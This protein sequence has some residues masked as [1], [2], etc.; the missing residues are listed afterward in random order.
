MTKQYRLEKMSPVTD[1]DQARLEAAL[2]ELDLGP[3]MLDETPV[4]L[5]V[6]LQPQPKA[7]D[8]S[9]SAPKLVAQYVAHVWLTGEELDETLAAGEQPVIL[10]CRDV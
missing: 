5:V 10:G 6:G 8:G 7:E 9:Q 1:I 3:M 4:H 2:C